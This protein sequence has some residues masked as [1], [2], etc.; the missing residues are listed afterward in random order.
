[1]PSVEPSVAMITSLHA[2]SAVL[3]ANV[4]PFT[5]AISGTSPLSCEKVVNVCVSTA[6]RGPMSSSPGRP[7]PPSPNRTS[8]S[9]KRWASS[10]IRS[11]L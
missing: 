9:R 10:N 11:C 7:P 1:M 2:T 5:T 6:T 4:R 8:G 3:P